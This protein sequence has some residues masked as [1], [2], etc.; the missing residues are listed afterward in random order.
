MRYRYFL[1]L[2]SIFPATGFS[3]D[4]ELKLFRPFNGE[5]HLDIGKVVK[6]VCI[7]QSLATKRED[8]FQCIADKES[9]DPCFIKEYGSHKEALCLNSP[10]QN[11]AIQ[12]EMAEPVD[13]SQ[14]LALDMSKTYP[15]AL[16]LTTGE[17]CTAVVDNES[18][19]GLK[20][21]Y[22]CDNG[23]FLVG[24]VQRCAAN[25]SILQKKNAD[26]ITAFIERAWF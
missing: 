9:F 4:T 18:F 7:S 10:W 23:S 3:K 25:W 24:H 22:R 1:I 20:I 13:N 12:I 21:H 16:L 11:Q 5:Y 8:A 14:H 6:G 15:W 19:D 2:L 17:K 26:V